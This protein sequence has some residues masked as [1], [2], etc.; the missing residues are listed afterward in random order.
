MNNLKFFVLVGYALGFDPLSYDNMYAWNSNG[1]DVYKVHWTVR[2]NVIYLALEVKTTGWVGFGIAEQS[3]GT[4]AGA[5]VVQGY[6]SK[7]GTIEVK[8]RYVLS[9]Y[10]GGNI[11]QAP[12]TDECNDWQIMNG[13]E[14]D[15]KT[16]LEL[17]R[18]IDTG[19]SQDRPILLDKQ[20]KIIMAYG[21]NEEDTLNN[22]HTRARR[23]A[24]AINFGEKTFS[25]PLQQ[26]LNDPDVKY[27]D[28]LNNYTVSVDQD[29]I[30]AQDQYFRSIGV[31]KVDSVD[32]PTTYVDY[33]MSIMQ[34]LPT[35]DDVYILGIDHVINEHT[36]EFVHHFVMAGAF[37]NNGSVSN[38]I[39]LYAWAPGVVP[40]VT[41]PHCG[42]L[43]SKTNPLGINL[44]T[45]S[46]HYDNPLLKEGILDMSGVRLYYK[47][48][49]LVNES[50]VEC[51]YF[52]IGQGF[53]F[54]GQA[55]LSQGLSMYEYECDTTSW[56][57]PEINIINS[58]LHMHVVGR[59][60]W[61]EQH[62]D[63]S[64]LRD[65]GRIDF[66]D[67]NFQASDIYKPGEAVVKKGDVLTTKCIYDTQDTKTKFG[68]ASL[69][70][71]CINFFIYYP[72]LSQENENA[73]AMHGYTTKDL[74]AFTYNF[75]QASNE[76]CPMS[77]SPKIIGSSSSPKIIESS[78]SPKIIEPTQ[79]SASPK[80][81]I[82]NEIMLPIMLISMLI[83][84]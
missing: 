72:R 38:S 41:S 32:G 35:D 1:Q 64:Y 45:L 43:L 26:L 27:V 12:M 39:Q 8:D 16:I 31:G 33:R 82:K 40:Q 21:G 14:V 42:F 17:S 57:Q 11:F 52:S 80:A 74:S 3:S 66:W 79:I 63:E 55:N 51:G 78:S 70:E 50:T 54:P 59:Q 9:Q 73:C 62:R 69:D 24:D 58:L 75:G 44:L 53:V 10:P 4:M 48:K 15:G 25:D 6:V 77:S 71:M 68:L 61:T 36:M 13:T 83:Y 29:V 19:D 56:V 46:T 2:D 18:Q 84:H 5:D 23:K 49:S 7:T 47:K 81:I 60:I 65:I 20:T 67:F 34:A 76:T 22:Y 30:E 37:W 28:F